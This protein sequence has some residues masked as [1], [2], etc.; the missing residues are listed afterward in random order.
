MATSS[1][2]NEAIRRGR[3]GARNQEIP[4]EIGSSR[5]KVS[6]E[7][8]IAVNPPPPYPT[9]TASYHPIDQAVDRPML[10]FIECWAMFSTDL[11]I[12]VLFV[13]GILLGH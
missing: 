6:P 9:P 10:V 11:L 5:A 12:T 7:R 4:N 13:T 8:P 2:N 1:N 3:L